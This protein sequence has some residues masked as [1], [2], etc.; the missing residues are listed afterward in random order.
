MIIRA[1]KVA[2]WGSVIFAMTPFYYFAKLIEKIMFR[3]VAEI[4]FID[5]PEAKRLALIA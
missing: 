4:E 5:D 3:A 2:F 1:A